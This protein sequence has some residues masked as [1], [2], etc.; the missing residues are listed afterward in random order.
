MRAPL[1][2]W[3]LLGV[4]VIFLCGSAL[5]FAFCWSG[6]LAVVAPFAAVNESVWE[7]LKLAFWPSLAY[8]LI[9]YG[10]FGRHAASFAVAKAVGILLMPLLIVVFFYGYT[11][12]LKHHV[13]W[14]DILLF[15]IAVAAGQLTS[16][17]L[18][19]AERPSGRWNVVG[20]AAVFLL[21]VG[22]TVFT[23]ATPRL[24]IFRD[25]STGA[26]GIGK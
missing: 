2:S 20:L 23:F 5:H 16:Y 10:F 8:G 11:A 13:L 22:F 3:E 4:P 9:E 1:L 6:R 21:G 15:F 26:Y 17:G 18:L 25:S 7:H 14:L 12:V 19:K 24:P